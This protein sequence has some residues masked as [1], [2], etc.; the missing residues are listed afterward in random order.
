V[1]T[2]GEIT[3]WYVWMPSDRV[4]LNGYEEDK[5][6][7]VNVTLPERAEMRPQVL[8][9]TGTSQNAPQENRTETLDLEL[10]FPDLLIRKD[11][12]VGDDD[13]EPLE[14]P[15]NEAPA[16]SALVA[17][18]AIGLVAVAADRRRRGW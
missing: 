10:T 7:F 12:I 6:V 4:E 2:H 5:K 1:F 13:G 17:M 8:R 3:D 18:V 11:N 16:F 15:D 14:W 9:I